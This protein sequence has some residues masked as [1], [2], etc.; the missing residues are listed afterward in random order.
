MYKREIENK[1]IDA[2]KNSD[3]ADYIE[4]IIIKNN[5]V[6]NKTAIIMPEIECFLPII[7]NF[8]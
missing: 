5:L 8:E 1:N 3:I 4:K 2:L 6:L 7:Q